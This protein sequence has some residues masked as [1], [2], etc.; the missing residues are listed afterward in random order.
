[1]PV[2]WDEYLENGYLRDGAPF[3]ERIMHPST[4]PYWKLALIDQSEHPKVVYDRNDG[5]YAEFKYEWLGDGRTKLVEVKLVALGEQGRLQLDTTQILPGWHHQDYIQI[6]NHL[7]PT[8]KPD[9][10]EILLDT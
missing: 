9:R 2:D 10:I 5:A 8:T 4:Q 6:F 3:A 7:H 1:M